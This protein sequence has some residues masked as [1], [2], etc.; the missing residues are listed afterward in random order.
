MTVRVLIVLA[1]G[2]FT[3][4][5]TEAYCAPETV[6]PAFQTPGTRLQ[7]TAPAARRPTAVGHTSASASLYGNVQAGDE[8][9]GDVA[10][11]VW[12]LQRRAAE[13]AEPPAA[14]TVTAASTTAL[15]VTWTAP[16]HATELI[17]YDLQYR[18]ASG[19]AFRDRDH[20]GTATHATISGLAAG[21]D[22]EVRVR[23][24]YTFGPGDWSR[25]GRGR[26]NGAAGGDDDTEGGS[27]DGPSPPNTAPAFTSPSHFTV[28]E[29]RQAVAALQATDPD[30]GDR[31]AGYAISGGPDRGAF[32]IHAETGALTFR[33]APDFERPT[34]AQGSNTYIVAVQ[35]S[36][37]VAARTLT[38]T[39]TITV[40]VTDADHEAPG[41]PAPPTVAIAGST[42]LAVSWTVP[43]NSGPP[44]T[45]YDIRHRRHA[46]AGF[47]D[48]SYDGTDTVAD[49]TPSPPG[50]SH[51]VQVR[52]TN[53]EGTSPWS[54]SG[55]AARIELPRGFA[56]R[57]YAEGVTDARSMALGAD[58][59]LFVGTRSRGGGRI[60]ALR[61]EDGD[62]WAERVVTLA[63]G[64]NRPNGVAVRDG[65]LYVA[66]I[67]RVLRYDDIEAYLDDPP[68]PQVVTNALPRDTH[69]GWKFIRF[70]PDG[71]LY[72]PVGAPCNI[73]A[74]S[75]PF[76]SIGKLDV[77]TGTFT[78]VAR[79]VRNTVGFDWHPETD[80]LWFTENG[81]DWLGD[82][83]PP[84]E[85]N[86]LGAQ[87]QHFGY[88]YCHGSD[89]QDPGFDDRPCT[90]FVAPVQHLGPHVAALGMRF[91]TG[92]MFPAEY[93]NQIFLA[94]HGSW[95]RSS[96]IGYRIMLVRLQGNVAT[97]Y[98]PFATGWLDGQ[99]N[100]GRPVDVLV[101]P[102]GAL[103]VSDDQGGAIYRI[104]YTD[105]TQT[106]DG[107]TP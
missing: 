77:T 40:T 64:L 66:E 54:E 97:S 19:A 43:V 80:E 58:G 9:A 39:Q 45:D 104:A 69:H 70:G 7:Q 42:S 38:A 55:H 102:D 3:A 10:A 60:Y 56:I 5:A 83:R 12:L 71:H 1:L 99:S 25:V 29:N 74:Q 75:D 17:D 16:E 47:T 22:Y 21:T 4:M 14:P 8:S 41:T 67:N 62:H 63:S 23:A 87:G 27:G 50:W 90:D 78:V 94:E 92:D 68:Q 46:G 59:T 85:L 28:Q 18:A 32:G 37:G 76:A 101:M 100:W 20:I 86:R 44:I 91:Y 33:V 2:A 103:L 52:A 84:D 11:V 89:I 34:D 73:C 98:E 51:E 95:N 6:R 48:A 106:I 82:D 36:S 65:D 93:R 88:P 49:I 105:G 81:R 31:I 61:D 79:G 107:D 57:P 15:A 30:A 96:K 53:A 24:I 35:A 26:T 13:G 72:V